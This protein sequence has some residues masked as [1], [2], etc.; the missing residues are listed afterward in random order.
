MAA[1]KDR[2][3]IDSHKLI[4]HVPRVCQWL[5]G[6]NIYPIYMEIALYGGC[7]HRCVFCAFDYLKYKPIV[8]DEKH[9]K[10][11][12]ADAARKGVKAV[13]YAGE[14]EPLLYRGVSDI[15]RFTKE[16]GIDVAITSNGVMFTRDVAEKCLPYLSWFRASIDAGTSKTYSKVHRT[17]A[18]D[19]YTVL[20]NLETAVKIRNRKKYNCTIGAQFLLIPSNRSEVEAM[21]GK[22]RDI[23]LDYLIVK[24]YSQH[25]ASNNKA[26][27][28]SKYEDLF[29]L[30]KRLRKY[31]DGNFQ[32][33]FRRHAMEKL[34]QGDKPYRHCL[35]LPFV[36]HVT[37]EGDIYPCNSF[38]GNK[39][40]AFGNIY[41]DRFQD[42]WE[43][44]RRKKIMD[45]IYN[46]WDLS[47]CRK[48]CR[49]DEI[50]RYLWGL[51]HPGSHV[52]FI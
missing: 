32:V 16:H 49:I 47:K 12:I 33:V 19:F 30:E 29:Y 4:H 26:G 45:S 31:S 42:I 13:M 10:K 6:E 40:F 48:V 25:P 20:R 52:N 1:I 2:F 50:N 7:N 41:K 36:A 3:K 23:G 46:N 14:G 38:L 15:V 24:P 8:L 44:S 11:F 39:K 51:K 43:G 9:L 21:A 28:K 27:Y 22:A 37:Q 17:K 5:K 34:R 35:G 18:G